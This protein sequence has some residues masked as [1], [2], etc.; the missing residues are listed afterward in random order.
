[1]VNLTG[2][3]WPGIDEFHLLRAL[4]VPGAHPYSCSAGGRF[5]ALLP[6]RWWL[7]AAGEDRCVLR[8][9]SNSLDELAL[10]VGAKGF[11]FEVLD[12]PELVPVLKALAGRLG[13]AAGAS[14][15]DSGPTPTRSDLGSSN[16]KGRQVAACAGRLGEVP[17]TA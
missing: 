10:F 9:G 17:F 1:M 16:A 12:P 15:G 6:R 8:T 7:E 11:D 13:K 2:P 5:A 14:W 4:P 3:P